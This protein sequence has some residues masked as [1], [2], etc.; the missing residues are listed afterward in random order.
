VS[1]V[2]ANHILNANTTAHG[3]LLSITM[4]RKLGTFYFNDPLLLYKLLN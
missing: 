1:R 3:R 2:G 4:P